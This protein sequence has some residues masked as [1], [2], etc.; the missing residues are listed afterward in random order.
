MNQEDENIRVRAMRFFITDFQ[1]GFLTYIFGNGVSHQASLY[2]LQVYSYKIIYGFYQS[3]IG[4]VGELAVYGAIFVLV[5]IIILIKTLRAKL[6]V[7]YRF[8]NLYI[9]ESI[10][11]LPT[12]MVFSTAYS[13]VV[14]VCL[15]YI[16]DY[17]RNKISL[18]TEFREHERTNN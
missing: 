16:V 7:E 10:I 1:P 17:H 12:G 15:Y 5:S 14:L 3:D 4:I 6:P 18:G 11:S 8:F 9:I 13:I 2:G